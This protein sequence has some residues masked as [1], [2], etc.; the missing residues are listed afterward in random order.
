M[1][2]EDFERIATDLKKRRIPAEVKSV[3]SIMLDKKAEEVVV[4][5]LKGIS[6]ITDYMVICHGNSSRQNN[7]VSSEVKK[8][9]TKKHKAKPFGIEGEREAEWIL[10]DYIDFVVHIFSPGTRKKYA[11]EKLWMDAKRYNFYVD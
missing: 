8:S 3:V 6:D 9:L 10:M 5:K 2:I 1:K 7:A 4:L 11:L